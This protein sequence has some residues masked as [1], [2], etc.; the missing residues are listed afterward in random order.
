MLRDILQ[1]QCSTVTQTFSDLIQIEENINEPEETKEI[2]HLNELLSLHELTDLLC[3]NEEDA[4]MYNLA[5]NFVESLELVSQY[6]VAHNKIDSVI[7]EAK[8]V[9]NW[10]S[11]S[12]WPGIL[13]RALHLFLKIN[14]QFYRD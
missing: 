8:D 5:Y 12:K 11:T 13:E 3:R 14:F 2:F 4:M 1:A 10:L 6:Q 9:L 7:K